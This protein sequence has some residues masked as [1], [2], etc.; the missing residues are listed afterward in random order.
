MPGNNIG[1]RVHNFFAQDNLPEVQ[2]SSLVVDGSWPELGNNLPTGS[3]RHISLPSSNSKSYILQ[4]SV[5]HGLNSAEPTLE[6]SQS[7]S[8]LLNLNGYMHGHQILRPK[9]NEANILGV[10]TSRGLSIYESQQGKASVYHTNSVR[11]DSSESP[12]NFDFFGSQQQMIGQQTGMLHSFPP[13]QSGF[14]DV[15]LLQ[16]QVMLRK[17]QELQSQQSQIQQLDGRQHNSADQVPLINGTPITEASNYPWTAE[18]TAGNSSWLQ[19]AIPAI[20]GSS[21]GFKFS[22]EQD[23]AMGLVPQ[24]GD[25]SLYGVPISSTGGT[26]NQYQIQQ[27]MMYGNFLP[28]NQYTGFS[29]QD[30]MQH[31]LIPRQGF[32]MGNLFG[33]DSDQGR[34]N[35]MNLENLR[36]VNALQRNAPV[37]EFHEQQ[38]LARPSETLQESTVLPVSSSQ[39]TVALDPTEERILFGDD[40]LWDAFGSSANIGSAVGINLSHGT[41]LLNGF[42]S[43]QSGSWSALMQSAVAETSSSGYDMS[44]QAEWGGMGFQNTEVLPGN[45]QS[46][47]YEDNMKQQT[48]LS[49]NNMLSSGT[50]T[51]SDDNNA[52][53]GNQGIPGF[54]KSGQR[55]SYETS[56]RPQSDSTW[57]SI[58]HSTEG[59]KWLSRGP[60][61]KP[62]AEGSQVYT[63]AY[64]SLDAEMNA[65]NISRAWNPQQG[66]LSHK[67]SQLQSTH[68]DHSINDRASGETASKIH[69]NENDLPS[70]RND[71]KRMVYEEMGHGGHYWRH[72]SGSN[73]IIGLEHVK[74]VMKSPQVNRED[75]SL[76][77]LATIPNT[78]M[79]RASQETSQ[80][81]PHSHNYWKQVDS[82]VKSKSNEDSLLYKGPQVLES[83]IN[84]SGR[85]TVRTHERGSCDQKENSSDSHCSN[86]SQHKGIGGVREND[87][88]DSR[89]L[90]AGKQNLPIQAGQRNPG[91]RKFQ[92]HPMGNLD[93]DVEAS[94]EVRH[95]I[96][97]Q[98]MPHHTPR[99]PYSHNQ[100]YFGQS[101]FFGQFS[102]A[103]AEMEKGFSANFQGNRKAEEDGPSRGTL[104]GFAQ[105][106]SAA[107]FAPN[108]ATESSQN[109]LELLHK[110]DQ[111]KEGGN[112][113]GPIHALQQHQ[114]SASQGFGLQLA[115]PSQ[116]LPVQNRAGTSQSSAQ[117]DSSRSSYYTNL[118]IREKGR[119]RVA[120]TA[121]GQSLPSSSETSQQET[122]TNKI[123]MPGQTDNEVLQHGVQGNF[124]SA[125]TSRI[126]LQN[127]QID[128]F[129][130]HSQ[131]ADDHTTLIGQLLPASLAHTTKIIPHDIS[132]SSG[133][134]L[135]PTDTRPSHERVSAPKSSVRQAEPSLQPFTS[136]GI[137]QQ[138]ALPKRVPTWTGVPSQQHSFSAQPH[139]LPSNI[140]HPSK[141]NNNMVSTSSA[142]WDLE[143]QDDR[144]RRNIPSNLGANSINS[145][146]FVQREEQP[147]KESL[148]QLVSTGKTNFTENT[149]AFQGKES[150]VR[151]SSD[152]SPSS[153]ASSQRDIEAFGRSLKPKNP[154]HQNYS[155]LHQM[156]AMKNTEI[157]PSI[158]DL[159]RLKG[160]DGLG[161]QITPEAGHSDETNIIVRDSVLPHGAVPSGDSQMLSFPGPAD[162]RES[163]SSSQLWN[164]SSQDVSAFGRKDSD[165]YPRSY[166][167]AS[168]RPENPQISP[169]MAPSWFNQFGTFK[170]GQMLSMHDSQK[171]DNVTVQ[172]PFTIGKTSGRPHVHNSLELGNATCLN[173]VDNIWQRSAPTS[174][175]FEHVSSAQ[176]RPQD[177][178]DRHLAVT[179][180]KKRKNA[181][182]KPLP[183]HK[184]VAQGSRSI[185]TISMAGNEWAKAANRL[186]D[187]V[188]DETD[189]IEDGP[190]IVRPKRRLILTTEL[191]QQLFRPPPAAVLSSDAGSNFEPVAYVVARLALGDACSLIP[192]QGSNDCAPLDSTNLSSDNCKTHERTGDQHLSRVTE[193]L[194]GRARKLENDFIRLYRRASVLDLRIESQEI[195]KFSMVNRF[196]KFYGK[197]QA[198]GTEPSSSSDA[199]ANAQRSFPPGCVTVLPM[200]KN[201]PERVQCLSL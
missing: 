103:S 147:A 123:G 93:E 24:Q 142:L 84:S 164:V 26:P 69:G 125:F 173:Q 15:Q 89:S 140:F 143:D 192:C 32:Q 187:K 141:S 189:I 25:Q 8:E 13:Q 149:T 34:D 28:G 64:H 107:P 38:E 6:K 156:Q 148:D 17:L 106:T 35:V 186:M 49:E 83:S 47:T 4:Q 100:G 137:S 128:N 14:N 20:Q 1:D 124:S 68:N 127:Q 176:S 61:Q 146:G 51:L 112:S 72:D 3:H 130:A 111:S 82:S 193:D 67:S 120:S 97:S 117:T 71:Q 53:N 92:Y 154:L 81:L 170:S 163:N 151:N 158:R 157:D 41:G 160:A 166:G 98:V 139:K 200:P 96:H 63:N 129:S 19:R 70:L 99:A 110:V 183:W 52:G 159:K 54:Q 144:K 108:K 85:D 195:E 87:G 172:Q 75:S 191:M 169:Q 104:P 22:S 12:V 201:V 36:Q 138:G 135:Q 153:S 185:I 155:L 188:E 58:Q 57:R 101:K 55:Y 116:W 168:G 122:D 161:C 77:N 115:P 5:L 91:P 21:N 102:K 29:H 136:S 66:V 65:K 76:N 109:M 167:T 33:H 181:T 180:E 74:P 152:A 31:G 27:M 50:M 80:L 134:A 175:A 165:N 30:N 198:D 95:P 86:L 133:D 40:N 178:G 184:E 132:A 73:S 18:P 79:A 182:T 197:G 48:V 150:I 46:S 94:Y 78:S 59:N 113:D 88:S 37:E 39:N 199:A 105:N 174:V 10:D 2:R 42:P 62:L 121:Q 90:P 11:S 196:A 190:P 23:Q 145:Q 45:H 16:K 119:T 162:N 177:V 114:S 131:R 9:Q 171:I 60:L 56:E 43:L 7:Q 179:R 194:I 126:K 118:E 44:I